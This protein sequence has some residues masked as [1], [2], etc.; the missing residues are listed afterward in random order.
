MVGLRR[1]GG[2]ARADPAR[3]SPEARLLGGLDSCSGWKELRGIIPVGTREAR[4]PSGLCHLDP[5]RD[6]GGLASCP[7]PRLEL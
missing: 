1:R 4:S 3:T 7:A 6:L 5:P 2:P